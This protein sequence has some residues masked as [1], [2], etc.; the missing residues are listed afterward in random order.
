NG[1]PIFDGFGSA[2][3]PV[4]GSPTD[5][6][7]MT[8]RGPNV[9]GPNG[10]KVFVLP[11]FTPQ[12][13]RFRINADG[14]VTLV[15]TVL[16]KD[17]N[18]NPRTGL[19]KP[20]SAGGTGETAVDQ[21]GNMPQP[22]QKGID[23]EG[24]VALPDGTFWVSDEYGPY[25]THFAADGTTLAQYGPF[26]ASVSGLT[27][28]AGL[29]QVLKTRIPNKGMEGLTVTPDANTQVGSMKLPAAN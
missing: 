3:A 11:S 27:I 2:L 14:T 15:S 6:Y 23:S 19:P 10:S 13:G 28:Q 22:D 18:G 7:S 20:S 29:P 4:P 8:D 9:D 16:L 26:S 25:L 12:I 17:Q 1:V 5:F 24:L 21:N